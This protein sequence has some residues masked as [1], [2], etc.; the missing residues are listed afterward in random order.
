MFDEAKVAEALVRISTSLN[1]LG[2]GNAGTQMGAI[3]AHGVVIK[4]GAAEIASAINSLAEAAG[5]IAAAIDGL[6]KAIQNGRE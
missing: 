1:Y 3:E 6:A 4:D 2:N 5:G